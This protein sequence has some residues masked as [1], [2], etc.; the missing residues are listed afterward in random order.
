[1]DSS[2]ESSD[3]FDETRLFIGNIPTDVDEDELR[4]MFSGYGRIIELDIIRRRNRGWWHGSITFQNVRSAHNLL[5]SSFVKTFTIEC[6]D[7]KIER[8]K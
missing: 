7:L 8:V 5:K 6:N 1:M 4:Q 3:D 2:E